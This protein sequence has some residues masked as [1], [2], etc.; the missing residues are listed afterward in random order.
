MGQPLDEN[1]PEVVPDTSPQALER[2]PN[3]ADERDKYPVYYDNAPK[4]PNE[5]YQHYDPNSYPAT[6][7]SPDGSI[8]WEHVSTTA[9]E[10]AAGDHGN[11]PQHRICGL[12]RRAF[13]II[14]ALTLVIIAVAV[15]GGVGGGLASARSREGSDA[16][17]SS[18]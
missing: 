1:L 10:T 16:A 2:N 4:I 13:Y 7:M 18:K 17:E 9:E 6:A 3:Q 8:P 14:L 11:Y 5:A 12:R 15:G